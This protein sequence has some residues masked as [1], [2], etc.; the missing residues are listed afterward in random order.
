[1]I[2]LNKLADLI[3]EDP[4]LPELESL[5]SGKGIRIAREGDVVD[6]VACLRYYAGMADKIQGQF[7]SSWSVRRREREV[8]C[9][10]FYRTAGQTINHYGGEK[11]IYTLH[12]PIG[13]CGQM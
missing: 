3:E 13:V 8:D 9:E 2:V 4:I 5:N 10:S 6:T 12:E 11:L 1:M 7:R